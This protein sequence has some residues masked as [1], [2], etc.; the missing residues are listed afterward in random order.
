MTKST[1]TQGMPSAKYAPRVKMPVT[2]NTN[3]DDAETLIPLLELAYWNQ[4]K[5]TQ[6][7]KENKSCKFAHESPSKAVGHGIIWLHTK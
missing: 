1:S 6:H 2:L 5:H 4:S 7:Y 3:K